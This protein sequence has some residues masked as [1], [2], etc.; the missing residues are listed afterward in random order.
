MEIL[1]VDPLLSYARRVGD[2]VKVVLVVGPAEEPLGADIALRLRSKGAAVDVPAAVA[3]VD[4]GRSRIEA[5]LPGGEVGDGTWRLK[6]LGRATFGRLNLQTRLLL[7][8]G[9]P[10]ALL[11]GPSPD[12]RLPEPAPTAP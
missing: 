8:A 9:M 12:T 6:L 3:P 10:V 2:D 11:P 5:L 7:R 1:P 4:G